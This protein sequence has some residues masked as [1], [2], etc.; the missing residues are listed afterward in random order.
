M[1]RSVVDPPE[2]IC[3]KNRRQVR[4]CRQGDQY[5][6]IADEVSTAERSQHF[7][8]SLN[9]SKGRPKGGVRRWPSV[10]V[11][12]R[13][14]EIQILCGEIGVQEIGDTSYSCIAERYFII[15]QVNDGPCVRIGENGEI[16]VVFVYV[17]LRS[18]D[19]LPDWTKLSGLGPTTIEALKQ[20]RR[21]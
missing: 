19:L 9:K 20:S 7:R 14:T 2:C 11:A 4:E 13:N 10:G 6:L 15:C 1:Q 12:L 8:D 5:P 21:S 17:R 16:Q 3:I 18:L